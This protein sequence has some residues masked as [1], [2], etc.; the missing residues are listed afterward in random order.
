MATPRQQKLALAIVENMAKEQPESLGHLLESVG[1]SKNVAEAKPGEIIAQEGVQEELKKLGFSDETLQRKHD[2]LLNASF[3]ERINFDPLDGDEV[4][5]ELIGKMEGY[6]LLHIINRTH[7]NGVC[8]EK[9]AYVKKPDTTVQ[10]RA[11]DKAYKLRG[12]YAPDKSISVNF[13]AD[14][15]ALKAI[16]GSLKPKVAWKILERSGNNIGIGA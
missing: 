14:E 5:H 13:E 3:M 4:V 15:K 6:T 8:Y 11:L 10:D 12:D 7:A 2:Q 1:Y 16:I 9:F